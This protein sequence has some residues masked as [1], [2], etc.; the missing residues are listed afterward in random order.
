VSDSTYRL[1]GNAVWISFAFLH[2]HWDSL[3]LNNSIKMAGKRQATSNLN[4][5]NWDQEEEPE[6]RGTFRTA[7]EQELKTRVIKKARRKI[8]GGSSAAGEDGAEVTPA[9]SKSVFSGFTG[10][11][12]VDSG[13]IVF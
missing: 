6:E 9:E 3:K 8:A 2:F 5:D 11:F 1:A 13:S 10:G 4:H 7:S 12:L